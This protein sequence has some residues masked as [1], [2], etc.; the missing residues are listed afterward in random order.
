MGPFS[1]RGFIRIFLGALLVHSL[2]IS[3]SLANIIGSPTQNFNP[4]YNGMD[5][6]T[7]HS[8]RTL[9]KYHLNVGFFLD[10]AYETLPAYPSLRRG[11]IQVFPEDEDIGDILFFSH[12]AA[13]FGLTHNWDIGISIPNIVGQDIENDYLKGQYAKGGLMEIRISSKLHILDFTDMAGLALIGSAGFNRTKD[14]P[15]LGEKPGPSISVQLALDLK[16]SLWDIAANVGYHALSPGENL[17]D[18]EYFKPFSDA[19]IASGALKLNLSAHLSLLGEIWMALY[20]VDLEQL[21]RENSVIEAL[22]GI[23]YHESSKENGSYNVHM[24]LT[25]GINHGVSTPGLRLYMGL[26]YTLGPIFF[27]NDP[28]PPQ[29]LPQVEE[30]SEI[31]DENKNSFYYEGYSQGYRAGHGVGPYAGLGPQ[32]GRSLNQ[33]Y[34]FPDGYYN[35][36]MDASASSYSDIPDREDWAYCYHLGFRGQSGEGPAQGKNKNYGQTLQKGPECA[37][38]FKKGWE[39]A[40]HPN[41]P[42]PTSSDDSFYNPGY[43]QGYQAGYGVGPYAGLGPDYG[44]QVDIGFEFSEGYYDGYLDAAGPFPGDSDRRPYPK[45][46]R[47]GFHGKLG[48]G[49]GKNKG[50]NYG[51]QLKP[52]AQFI[53]GYKQGWKDAPHVKQEITPSF[54]PKIPDN[55]NA[56]LSYDSKMQRVIINETQDVLTHK[57]PEE[58]ER[59]ELQRIIFEK[60]TGKLTADSKKILDQVIK[61]LKKYD[62]KSLE[63]WGH[64]SSKGAALYNE[65]LSI[66]RAKGVFNYMVDQGLDGSK[67]KFDGWGERKPVVPNTTPENLK[68]NYR[69]ELIIRR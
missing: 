41:A 11:R 50:K 22:L 35:G 34:E 32:K 42:T 30:Q 4:V 61:Y 36:Y 57:F 45:G 63:I 47:I 48:I 28:S 40:P 26:N 49:P 29:K 6:T 65:K 17:N 9:K 55:E 51:A 7:V 52:K 38:G 21:R 25:R 46:Y 68:R 33:G 54:N 62:F 59:L 39:E 20:D 10:Q 60:Q 3:Q 58:E 23:R 27:H 18:F 12:F 13:G 2:K 1:Y 14:L 69:I 24:G 19:F 43:R 67:M 37:K 64:T 31:I 44:P 16:E 15:Y 5:F 8:S 66:S 53:Q 56:N